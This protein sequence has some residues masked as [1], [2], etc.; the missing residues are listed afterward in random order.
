MSTGIGTSY[1]SGAMVVPYASGL[2]AFDVTT[3]SDSLQGTTYYYRAETFQGRLPTIRR[4]LVE[5]V[6]LGVAIINISLRGTI[7]FEA[8]E[9]FQQVT[10]GP[11]SVTIGTGGA[12]GLIMTAACDIVLTA[13]NPQLS[14][15]RSNLTGPVTIVSMTMIGTVEEVSL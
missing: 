13:Y 2:W 5:Y 7:G 9:T 10:A 8:N 14:W 3:L 11:T 12:T 6:D 15:T 4:V 1:A